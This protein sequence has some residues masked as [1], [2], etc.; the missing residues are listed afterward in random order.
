MVR[1]RLNPD[2]SYAATN[3]LSAS[4]LLSPNA[5]Q[6]EGLDFGPQQGQLQHSS[7]IPVS[8]GVVGNETHATDTPPNQPQQTDLGRAETIF[9]SIQTWS[10][11]Q[12]NTQSRPND[13]ALPASLQAGRLDLTPKASSESERSL[14]LAADL[15]QQTNTKQGLEGFQRA[16]DSKNPF[17]RGEA[18]QSIA[19][20]GSNVGGNSSVDIWAN[21]TSD[22]LPQPV[23][24]SSA[25]STT[26]N[27]GQNEP[28]SEPWFDFP[29]SPLQTDTQ[30]LMQFKPPENSTS[31]EA[32][33]PYEELVVNPFKDENPD[34]QEDSIGERTPSSSPAEDHTKSVVSNWVPQELDGQS[35]DAADRLFGQKNVWDDT[36]ASKAS[37]GDEEASPSLLS[38]PSRPN[39]QTK[40]EETPPP[41]PP[42]PQ[43]RDHENHENHIMKQR[44]ETYQIRLVNWHDVSSPRNP[45]QSPIM[46]QNANGPCPLLALVNA[47]TLSTPSDIDTGLVETLRTREQVSL[48][49]LL[50]AIIDE[51]ISG[52]RGTAT[53]PLPDVSELYTFLVTLH[54]GMNVNPSFGSFET[55]TPSL[56]DAPIAEVSNLSKAG[57]FEDTKEMRLYS[58]FAVPLIHG[59]V[60]PD[61]HPAFAALK[62]SAPTYEEAQ[63]LLF[64]EEELEEKLQ[65]QG[66]TEAE[67][68]LLEDV[69]RVK[70]FL[71]SSAT[72]LTAH[73]LDTINKAL[74]PG[75]IAILFRNNH[76]NTLYKH[77]YSGQLFTVI[78]D[79]G[80]AGH[81]EVVWES[82]VDVSGEG[83]EYFAG[84]FRPVGHHAGDSRPSSDN[85]YASDNQGWTTVPKS[86]ARNRSHNDTA[87]KSFSQPNPTLPPSTSFSLLSLTDDPNPTP[88]SP[89]AEQEDHDLALALQLQE[90]EEDRSRREAATRRRQEDELSQAYISSQ[91]STPRREAARTRPYP[92]GRGRGNFGAGREQ[93]APPLVPPRD[94]AAGGT[95]VSRPAATRSKPTANDGANDSDDAPPP[96]YEQA[97]NGPAFHP[98]TDHPAHAQSPSVSSTD[99]GGNLHAQR[100]LQ[101]IPCTRR[102]SAYAQNSSALRP[103]TTEPATSARHPAA[104]NT[105]NRPGRRKSGIASGPPEQE[106]VGEAGSGKDCVVM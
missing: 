62:R 48:G 54:T 72:Q 34:R 45:R 91:N 71:S 39:H 27:L 61:N 3:P 44:N 24:E 25:D 73:G 86:N 4:T 78:T 56:I 104:R 70:Y 40:T 77:P 32:S 22:S 82:L 31:N 90:E 66:L 96:S 23:G 42:R 36:T 87:Q 28:F 43:S 100:S 50:D 52:R 99:G 76:F 65:H 105:G 84:D 33:N 49:L 102:T 74:Q 88:T 68:I 92:R 1:R 20:K 46:V 83:C 16:S 11:G 69:G 19:N 64:R 38:L 97:A 6:L 75:S 57:S 41:K 106:P 59:W 63:N 98:P 79:M 21:M 89:M 2:G 47:L 30:D 85:A 35:I 37:P 26:K 7:N 67:Q 14:G 12:M 8:Q 93:T 94:R 15:D 55:P 18:P 9:P 101:G 17:L 81:D 80:Y 10:G 13:G 58:T 29:S 60:P 103:S 5:L 51:L 53:N 95:N